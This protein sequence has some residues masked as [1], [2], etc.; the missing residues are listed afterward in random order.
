M[1][2]IVIVE[3]ALPDKSCDFLSKF[4][5]KYPQA[6]INPF[7]RIEAFKDRTVAYKNIRGATEAPYTTV[8]SVLNYSR[9]L[10]Q[11]EINT[12][13]QDHCFPENTELTIWRQG[14]D[15][16]P[17]ADNCW[18]PDVDEETKK[19]KH[20]TRFRSYSGIFY[21]NDT[22]IGG[23][24]YFVNLNY[25]LK[26]KKGMFVGF[27]AGLEHTHQVLPIEAGNRYTIAIW[28]S[29]MIEYAE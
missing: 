29:N 13:Y 28:Y 5:E 8:S 17:H 7:Q 15:M 25:R 3:N 16:S 27:K 20:P 4:C 12:F 24:I 19:T 23:D 18:Q 1:N 6:F 10:G 2:D 14:Q 11:R 22:F 26:P 9:F 21:L